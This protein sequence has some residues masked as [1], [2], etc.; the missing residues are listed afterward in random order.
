MEAMILETCI[1]YNS[2]EHIARVQDTVNSVFGKGI[3][4]KVSVWTLW[5]DIHSR[6][7]SGS[8]SIG[9]LLSNYFTHGRWYWLYVSILGTMQD[10]EMKW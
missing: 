6:E 5:R 1:T 4:F 3:F 9:N 10:F 7:F 8:K 2:A